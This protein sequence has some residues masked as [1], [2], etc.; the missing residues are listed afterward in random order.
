M[1]YFM[2]NA[3]DCYVSYSLVHGSYFYSD[4][5]FCFIGYILYDYFYTW[6]QI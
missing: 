2:Q 6:M 4:I 1:D 5:Y 3:V